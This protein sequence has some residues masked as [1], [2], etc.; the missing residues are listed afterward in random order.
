MARLAPKST[1]NVNLVPLTM[2]APARLRHDTSGGASSKASGNAH[3]TDGY[4]AF[5]AFS[6]VPARDRDAREDSNDAML[7]VRSA[8]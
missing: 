7:E 8:M 4:E 5:Q 3:G 2:S 1:R 6:I